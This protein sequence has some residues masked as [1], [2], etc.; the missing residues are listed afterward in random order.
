MVF[1]SEFE[2]YY[3]TC[4]LRG[5][6]RRAYYQPWF[7]F[8]ADSEHYL[9]LKMTKYLFCERH[10]N[11]LGPH[12]F[13]TGKGVVGEDIWKNIED[14]FAKAGRPVPL[15]ELTLMEWRDA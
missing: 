1:V 8:S 10:K 3:R 2:Q 15:K 14:S 5:C 9:V 11:V 13:I 12:D 6:G 4:V 7:Y